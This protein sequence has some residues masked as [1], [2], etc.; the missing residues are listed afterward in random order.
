MCRY[1]FVVRH[2]HEHSAQVALFRPISVPLSHSGMLL[3]TLRR[4]GDSAI[5]RDVFGVAFPIS[6]TAGRQKGQIGFSS[7]K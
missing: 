2:F 4:G 5:I 6:G 7:C 1:V 3:N